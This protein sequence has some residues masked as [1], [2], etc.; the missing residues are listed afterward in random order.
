MARDLDEAHELNNNAS[1]SRQEISFKCLFMCAYFEGKCNIFP[2]KGYEI[3]E[4]SVSLP[5]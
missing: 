4:K 3:G 5:L 1:T 2:E